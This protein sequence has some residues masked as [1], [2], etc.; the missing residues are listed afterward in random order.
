M[1]SDEMQDAYNYMA[2][3]VVPEAQFEAAE[4]LEAQTTKAGRAAM[5][6]SFG[7]IEG[8]NAFVHPPGGEVV[9]DPLVRRNAGRRDKADGAATAQELAPL[10]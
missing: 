6:K 8:P 4:A 3:S 7:Q 10:P 5:I 1:T 9:H 2:S